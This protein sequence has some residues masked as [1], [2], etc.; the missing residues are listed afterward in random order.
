[1][2]LAQEH[3]DA[4]T[5]AVNQARGNGCSGSREVIAEFDTGWSDGKFTIL[6][7]ARAVS[8]E[9]VRDFDRSL[10]GHLL[11]ELFRQTGVRYEFTPFHSSLAYEFTIK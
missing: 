9:T 1:M 4:I 10:L 2:T 5:K 3:I 6:V 8:L 7:T 11:A